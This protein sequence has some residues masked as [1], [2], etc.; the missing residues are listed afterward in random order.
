MSSTPSVPGPSLSEPLVGD[1]LGRAPRVALLAGGLSHERDVS[2]RSGRRVAEALRSAGVE[3]SVHDV[4]ADLLPALADLQ[5]DL[6]WPVLHGASGE[7]GSVRDIVQLSGLRLLGTGPRA[8]RVA[9]SKP[10]AK[11]VAARAGLE[12]PEFVTLPQTL[13]REL[14][15]SA[16]LR[17]I[18]A[19][20]GLPV[21]VKPSR[22]GSALGVSLVREADDLPRAMVECF[23]YSD[24]ALVE[25]AVTGTELAA[26]VVDLGEGPVALPPVEIVADGPYDYDARYNPGR[27]EYFAPAR[28]RPEQV[29]AVGAAAVTAHRSLGLMGLSRT[30]L[31]LDEDGVVHFL[32]VNV[33]PGMTETSLFP[34]AAEAAGYNLGT[35]Y[36]SLVAA[37]LAAEPAG[38]RP[39]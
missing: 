11:T 28:L 1:R 38:L 34:Q 9:W 37:S 14:G 25:R 8:S 36:R 5:P 32:E 39:V 18:V 4:D 2:M 21:V 31:I 10:I 19:R 6:V 20:L 27:V 3:V 17:M 23:S 12:T 13:F 33:A 24:T 30:D 15:A 29:E 7:D 35:L 16:V 22:G 26:S